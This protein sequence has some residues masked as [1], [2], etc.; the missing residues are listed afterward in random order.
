MISGSAKFKLLVDRRTCIDGLRIDNKL[1]IVVRPRAIEHSIATRLDSQLASA[2]PM[3]QVSDDLPEVNLGVA[4]FFL[5]HKPGCA[6]GMVLDGNCHES[7]GRM[8]HRGFN[9]RRVERE[10]NS[11]QPALVG[12]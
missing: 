7:L 6:T 4:G 9:A 10:H 5:D 12:G 3:V 8:D 11:V 1:C 2:T